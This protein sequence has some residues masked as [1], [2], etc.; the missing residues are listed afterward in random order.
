MKLLYITTRISGA[1]GLQRVLS[2]K[3]DY[4]IKKGYEVALLVT[5]ADNDE[6]V[7]NFNPDISYHIIAPDRSFFGYFNSYKKLI[8]KK[9]AEVNPDIVIVCDNGLKGFLLPFI[10]GKKYPLIY[11]RHGSKYIEEKAGGLFSSLTKGFRHKF[12]DYGASG[13][14]KFIVLTDKACSE[15]RLN[16]IE[17]IPNPL[18]FH[19]TESS[20][21]EKNIAVAVGRHTYEK[22]YDRLF[23]IWA[24]VLNNN[25]S[26][27]LKVYGDPNPDYD[28]VQMAKDFGIIENV[29]FIAAQKNILP[30]YLEASVFLMGSR[31]EGFGM[32]LAEAMACGVPCV[33]FDCPVG[34]SEI[35]QDGYNGFL[36]T[37]DDIK[38]YTAKV[39]ML[40]SDESLRKKMGEQAKQSVSKFEI[41]PIMNKWIALFNSLK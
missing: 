6:V 21:L 1:G 10:L 31:S 8:R 41:E 27:I 24:G 5:N 9:V 4:L 19:T 35:I 25:P 12:M 30:A 3:T 26:W 38:D 17:V 20:D 7:Y 34:P 23:K 39:N 18:W 2:V 37:D 15:W 33:A 16:N 11:E 13:F 40:I 32:V 22:G 14:D 36:I 29:E 28:L